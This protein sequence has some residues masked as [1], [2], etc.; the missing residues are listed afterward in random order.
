MIRVKAKI[1]EPI[2]M[3][4]RRFKKTCEREGL[5]KEIKRVAFYE[6][7]SEVRRRKNRMAE[8][9]VQKETQAFVAKK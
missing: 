7:P 6:K 8:R 3:L 1:G 5:I 2:D 9:K 4:I